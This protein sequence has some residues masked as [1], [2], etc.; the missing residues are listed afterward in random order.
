V[1]KWLISS[2]SGKK[3]QVLVYN[4]TIEKERRICKLF[5]MLCSRDKLIFFVEKSGE[6]GLDAAS[7]DLGVEILLSFLER[8]SKSSKKSTSFK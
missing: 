6:F 7:V 5:F 2:S 8:L 3:A 1:Q 4:F